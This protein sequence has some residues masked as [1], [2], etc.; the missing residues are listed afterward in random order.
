M[1]MN[2]PQELVFAQEKQIVPSFEVSPVPG[3]GVKAKLTAATPCPQAQDLIWGPA[4][5]LH[6]FFASLS[7]QVLAPC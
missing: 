7:S 6:P 1:A 2:C 4:A 5:L 3:E